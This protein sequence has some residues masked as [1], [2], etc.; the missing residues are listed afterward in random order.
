[1]QFH[2]IYIIAIYFI[3]IHGIYVLYVHEYTL[4]ICILTQRRPTP[5]N[6]RPPPKSEMLLLRAI[7]EKKKSE[8]LRSAPPSGNFL[9]VNSSGKV[10]KLKLSQKRQNTET[11]PPPSLYLSICLSV[12]LSNYDYLSIC[13]SIYLSMTIYLSIHL[14]TFV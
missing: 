7:F 2:D 10:A 11:L 5:A 8:N 12:Y 9:F 4:Y 14:P 3:N 6:R 13:L 1:M